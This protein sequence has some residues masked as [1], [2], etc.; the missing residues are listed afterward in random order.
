LLNTQ[1]GD[2]N[3]HIGVARDVVAALNVAY[4]SKVSFTKPDNSKF[5]KF[6]NLKSSISERFFDIEACPRYSGIS[7]S[8][9]TVADSPDC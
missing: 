7:I 3:S 2:A 8:G 1:R 9:I 4:K 5:S 6:S